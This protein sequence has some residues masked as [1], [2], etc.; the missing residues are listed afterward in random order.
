MLTSATGVI[1]GSGMARTVAARPNRRAVIC[2][3]EVLL[4]GLESVDVRG[5]S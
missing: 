2:M 5:V 1:A 4:V 3:F